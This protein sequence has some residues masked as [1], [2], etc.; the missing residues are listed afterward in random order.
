M[1]FRV[2]AVEAPLTVRFEPSGMEYELSPG[3]HVDVEWPPVAPGEIAGDIEYGPGTV[4]IVE[5]GRGFSRAWNAAGVEV[6]T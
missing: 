3:E 4:T 5:R 1:K 6:T 2:A